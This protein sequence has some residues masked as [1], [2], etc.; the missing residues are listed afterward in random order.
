ML[1]ELP[2]ILRISLS[3]LFLTK[4]FPEYPSPTIHFASSVDGMGDNAGAFIEPQ[5]LKIAESLELKPQKSLSNNDSYNFFSK[6]GNL[7]ST[8]PT[9]TNV[10]DFRAILIFP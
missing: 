9:F 7:I 4:S 6:L 8:G 10:N 5:S 2:N 3:T 1:I